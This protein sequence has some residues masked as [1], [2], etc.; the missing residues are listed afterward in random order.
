MSYVICFWDKSKLQVT[1]T[2]GKKLQDAIMSE[3]IKNFKLGENLY[4]IGGVEK[5]I[6]KDEAYNVFPGEYEVLNSLEDKTISL[7]KLESAKLN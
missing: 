5:I 4:A 3:E 6:S 1:D 2:V 7:P